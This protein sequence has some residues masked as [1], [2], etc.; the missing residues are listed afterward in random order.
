MSVTNSKGVPVFDQPIIGFRKWNIDEN[1]G[2]LMSCTNNIPWQ[3]GINY[4]SG[5]SGS[6]AS[7]GSG[8]HCGFNAWFTPADNHSSGYHGVVGAIAAAGKVELHPT[9]FRSSEAQVIALHID[10]GYRKDIAEKI[11]QRYR[12]PVFDKEDDFLDFVKSFERKL[13]NSKLLQQAGFSSSQISPAVINLQASRT[14][15]GITIK[16]I[17]MIFWVIIFLVLLAI[18]FRPILKLISSGARALGGV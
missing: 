16:E 17:E 9:G 11:S 6:H 13:D 4:A 8:C 12:I 5:C 2:L 14:S 3:P 15:A 18:F 1:N 7:P 10:K